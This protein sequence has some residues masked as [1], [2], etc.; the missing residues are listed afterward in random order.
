M[1]NTNSRPEKLNGCT[2]RPSRTT[3]TSAQ[4]LAWAPTAFPTL[5]LHLIFSYT[6]AKRRGYPQA[7]KGKLRL[8]VPRSPAGVVGQ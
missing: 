2:E 8:R 5:G 7:T 3:G 6:L 1:G 4:H